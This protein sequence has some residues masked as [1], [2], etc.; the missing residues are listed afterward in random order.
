MED[1]AV[2]DDRPPTT[3]RSSSVYRD[4][5]WLICPVG[6][7]GLLVGFDAEQ[8]VDLLL[9]QRTVAGGCRDHEITHKLDLGLQLAVCEA[10]LGVRH[11]ADTTQQRRA[12][13]GNLQNPSPR[14][15]S[16]QPSGDDEQ[17]ATVFG[18][19]ARKLSATPP[20]VW[21][22]AVAPLPRRPLHAVHHRRSAGRCQ[23]WGRG[24]GDCPTWPLRC[25]VVSAIWRTPKTVSQTASCSPRSS[26]WVISWSRQPPAT[27]RCPRRRSTVCS[28]SKPTRRPPSRRQAPPR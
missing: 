22:I 23:S 17:H 11:M 1:V 12:T 8:T 5:C 14:I 3:H 13:L 16:G 10:V 28:A 2:H 25:C 18:A 9:G 15:G 19:T 20:E 4:D 6:L 24:S 21:P 27:V 7:G 26:L